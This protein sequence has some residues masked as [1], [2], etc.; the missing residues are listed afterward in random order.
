MKCANEGCS[1]VCTDCGAEHHIGWW[2]ICADAKGKHGHLPPRGM[3]TFK[4]YLDHHAGD[5]PIEV[6]SWKERQNLFK[7]KWNGDYVEQIQP[8]DKPDSYYRE[9]NQRREHRAEMARKGQH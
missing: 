7:P 3:M 9:L 6:R 5:Q 2:P 1:H 4:P 8:R